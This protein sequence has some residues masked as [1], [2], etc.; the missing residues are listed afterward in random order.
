MRNFGIV[1]FCGLR[2]GLKKRLERRYGFIQRKVNKSVHEAEL[3]PLWKWVKDST[4]NLK[5]WMKQQRG[6]KPCK[7]ERNW[8]MEGRKET[9]VPRSADGRAHCCGL[10]VRHKNLSMPLPFEQMISLFLEICLRKWWEAEKGKLYEQRCQSNVF[11]QYQGT[12][13][14]KCSTIQQGLN[15][16]ASADNGIVLD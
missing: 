15:R 11:L 4:S 12:R 7:R 10:S 9:G 3:N 5:T 13:S 1:H 6:R 8:M 14:F 16:W 2:P